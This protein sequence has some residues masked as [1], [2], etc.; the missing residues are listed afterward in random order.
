MCTE[1]KAL[2]NFRLEAHSF[3]K[4]NSFAKH[5][6]CIAAL[7]SREM[8]VAECILRAFL[9]RNARLGSRLRGYHPVAPR[10]LRYGLFVHRL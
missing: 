5:I 2:D 1:H 8:Y 7:C 3:I 4:R 10:P 9:V 6:S